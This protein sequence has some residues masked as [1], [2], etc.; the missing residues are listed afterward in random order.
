MSTDTRAKSE[1]IPSEDGVS[2][3][4]V[5]TRG[6]TVLGRGLSNL[7]DCNIEHPYFGHFRT[8]EGLWYYM[9]TGFADD[10]FRIIKGLRARELG[11]KM[12]SKLYP[13][14]NKMFK[15][16][17]LEKLDR[18]PT[19]Q[20]QLKENDLPL[21]HYYVYSDRVQ[22]LTHHQWQ[23]DFWQLL[24][25]ALINT[26]DLNVIRKEILDEI[27]FHLNSPDGLMNRQTDQAPK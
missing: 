1:F 14:F 19:L 22:P 20:K 5:Y 18:N 10:S 2:H 25:T 16:G 26:G 11:K 23:L 9:K 27:E 13:L 4:N 21:A 12:P 3:V 24:R 17:M 15:L 8:L 6:A 7:S